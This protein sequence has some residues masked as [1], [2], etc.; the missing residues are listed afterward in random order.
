M[1][2][3]PSLAVIALGA[4]GPAFAGACDTPLAAALKMNTIPYKLHTV[5]TGGPD[6][7]ANGGQPT[8]SDMVATADKMYIEVDGSWHSV[9]R[10][11]DM[12]DDAVAAMQ[13]GNVSCSRLRD[14]LVDGVATSVWQVDE[15]DDEDITRQTVWIAD[16]SGLMLRAEFEMDVGGGDAGKSSTTADFSYTDVTPPAGAE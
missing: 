3:I 2:L 15:K 11:K 16:D 10:P 12:G 1:R 5:T 8:A 13:A 7:A 6:A 9:P 14:E 4:G